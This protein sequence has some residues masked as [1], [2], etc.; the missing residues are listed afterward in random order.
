MFL[1]SDLHCCFCPVARMSWSP[2]T[3]ASW[4]ESD[5][6]QTVWKVASFAVQA[7]GVYLGRKSR[8]AHKQQEGEAAKSRGRNSGGVPS[9]SLTQT[10]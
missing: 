6:T 8:Q 10:L 4:R 1:A 7:Y 2:E 9:S 5:G 3:R